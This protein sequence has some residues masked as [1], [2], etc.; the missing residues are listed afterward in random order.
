MMSRFMVVLLFF[1]VVAFG[2]L[3]ALAARDDDR[4][5]FVFDLFADRA[6]DLLHV[7]GQGYHDADVFG[8]MTR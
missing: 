8:R 3:D 1:C 5:P 7:L 4:N 6:A 2:G